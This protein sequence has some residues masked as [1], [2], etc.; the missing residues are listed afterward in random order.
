M[1]SKATGDLIFHLPYYIFHLSLPVLNIYTNGDLAAMAN[2]KCNM[3]NGKCSVQP[4]NRV[5]A[6]AQ[7]FR[8]LFFLRLIPFGLNRGQ[9]GGGL[10]LADRAP[11]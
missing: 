10:H 7:I 9:I 3:T 1:K 11:G 5:M 8:L 2:D 4:L 6:Q